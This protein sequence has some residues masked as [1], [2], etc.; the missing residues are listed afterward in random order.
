MC[1]NCAPLIAG[2]L[3]YYDLDFMLS[4]SGDKKGDNSVAFNT[5]LRY[6]EDIF[7]INNTYKGSRQ[8]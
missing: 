1:A 3:F 2:A 4:L 6:L 5:I 7:N 8:I